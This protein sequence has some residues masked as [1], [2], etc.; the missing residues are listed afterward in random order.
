[1]T[2]RS[3]DE[4]VKEME[5]DS[6]RWFGDHARDLSTLVLGLVGESG[7]CADVLKKWMRGS[8][9]EEQMIPELKTEIIDVF[10]YWCLLVGLLGIDVEE[11]YRAKRE[12]NERRYNPGGVRGVASGVPPSDREQA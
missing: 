11:I 8:L 12:F 10:H 2:N 1:M 7:E 3:I 5:E 9:T 4:Y 6:Y